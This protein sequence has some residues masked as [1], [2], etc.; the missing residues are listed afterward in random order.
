MP[1]WMPLADFD[2]GE[3]CKY[4]SVGWLLHNGEDVKVLAPNMGS[5][6]SEHDVQASGIIQIP[7]ACVTRIVEIEDA[8]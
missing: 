1:G 3:I 2:P 7:S 5:V 4:T 8:E 6:A